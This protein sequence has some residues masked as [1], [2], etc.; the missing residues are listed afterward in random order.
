MPLLL[1]PFAVYCE[2][3]F[4]GQSLISVLVATAAGTGLALT[5]IPVHIRTYQILSSAKTFLIERDI[6]LSA[7]TLLTLVGMIVTA[8]TVSFIDSDSAP[9]VFIIVLAAYLVERITD[10]LARYVEFQKRFGFWCF[11]QTVRS[12]WL[13]LAMALSLVGLDYQIAALIIVC[14]LNI[15][16]LIGLSVKLSDFR[17]NL[18]G[19]IGLL[20]TST[21][22]VPTA[23]LLG[24]ARQIPRIFVARTFPEMVHLFVVL[25]QFSQGVSLLYN[26]KFLM[27]W[28]KVISRKPRLFE[29]RIS[30][31]HR[32]TVIVI[33]ALILIGFFGA[34]F[35]PDPNDKSL[36]SLL[37]LGSVC[38]IDATLLAIFG[39]YL[40]LTVWLR[41]PKM[42]FKS[43]WVM[44]IVYSLSI[45]TLMLVASLINLNIYFILLWFTSVLV[46][47]VVLIFVR[48][49]NSK[50]VS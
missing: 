45:M 46:A 10:E 22:Y 30:N 8:F 6:Y 21:I 40:E 20:K 19:V 25:S 28:R 17:L 16:Y 5:S 36:T 34:P 11:I 48:H 12:G 35:V 41:T 24:T 50:I 39:A 44:L 38:L 18:S 29:M 14:A 43:Y 49:F 33:A 27:P 7:V 42:V 32:K 3:I 2:S 1:R 9:L 23:I 26:V 37:F 4:F 31:I 15:G 47:V 13:L